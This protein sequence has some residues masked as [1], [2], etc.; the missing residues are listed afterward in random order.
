MKAW[1]YATSISHS[2]WD[3]TLPIAT[4][5]HLT[6]L[7]SQLGKLPIDHGMHY[8][9]RCVFSQLCKRAAPSRVMG[10]ISSLATIHDPLAKELAEGAIFR[11]KLL[12]LV[13]KV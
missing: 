12:M 2:L 6:G 13:E 4:W 9:L 7:R 8:S 11:D 10:S 3:I 5:C 1:C